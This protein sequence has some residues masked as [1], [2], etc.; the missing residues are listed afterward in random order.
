MNESH[1]GNGHHQVHEHHPHEHH[2]EPHHIVVNG[3]PR[4]VTEKELS[5]HAVCKL[6]FPEG[7]FGENVN[8]TVTFA[9]PHGPEGSMVQGESV[10]VKNGM[11]FNVGKSD[12]S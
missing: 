11:I 6:A 1:E 10:K 3:Q 4:E 9:D 8:Y 12:R 2:P 7:P 5:F